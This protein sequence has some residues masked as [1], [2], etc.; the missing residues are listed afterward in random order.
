MNR[1]E[2]NKTE[3]LK[4]TYSTNRT[5]NEVINGLKF[6]LLPTVSIKTLNEQNVKYEK[7]ENSIT[8]P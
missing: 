3:L 5:V 1:N 6:A 2:F 7:D 4:Y 8:I